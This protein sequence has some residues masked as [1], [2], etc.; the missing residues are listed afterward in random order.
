M[1]VKLINISKSY[2]EYKNE[3]IRVLNLFGLRLSPL[4]QNYVLKN[5]SFELNYGESIGILGK[6]GAGKSTLLKIISQNIRSF[7]GS[8]AING[9]SAAILELGMGFN[10]DMSGRENVIFACSMKG[11]STKAI[12]NKFKEIEEFADIGEYFNKPLRIYSSGMRLRLG[13]AV[14][15]AWRPDLLIIDE[16]LAVGDAAFQSKCFSRINQFKKKGTALIIVSHSTDTIIDHCER[17]LFLKDGSIASDGTPK[18]VSNIYLDY[19]YG[20][21]KSINSSEVKST[22]KDIKDLFKNEPEQYHN[23]PFYNKNEYRWGNEEATIMDYIFISDNNQYP[24]QIESNELTEIIFKVRFNKDFEEVLAG[25]LIKSLDGKSLFGT[26]SKNIGFRVKNVKKDEIRTFKFSL[27]LP[28]IKGQYLLSLG[29]S[30][31]IDSEIIPLDRRYDSI[32]LTINNQSQNLGI[33]DLKTKF[34]TS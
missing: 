6:N 28:F 30:Q 20:K 14:A 5:I 16:A 31:Y 10:E 2:K 1:I 9:S 12:E 4:N 33:V 27:I 8:M 17:A 23:R 29:I 32:F 24:P 25:I 22:I 13:F 15:T 21:K 19:L 26:N 7:S 34:E 18:D 11:F 3:W